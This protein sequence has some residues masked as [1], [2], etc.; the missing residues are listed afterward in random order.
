MRDTLRYVVL[1]GVFILPFLPL[2]VTGSLFFPYITGKNFAFRIIVEIIFAAWVLLALY[3]ARYRPQFSWILAAFGGFVSIMLVANVFGESPVRSFWS[4]F[5][6]MEGWITLVHLLAYFVVAAAVLTTEK[7]WDWFFNASLAAA[8]VVSLYAGFQLLGRV[9]IMQGGLR[10]DA[11]LGNAIYMAVYM[12]FHAFIALFMM[13]RTNIMQL[14]ILYGGLALVFMFLLVQTATR[15]TIL[16]LVGGLAVTGLYIALFSKGNVLL[17]KAALLGLVLVVAISAAFYMARDTAFVRESPILSR[18]ASISLEAGATRFTIWSIAL[19]GVAER[20]I[21]G[22]GQGNFDYVFNKYYRPSLYAQEPWFDRVHNIILDWMV[23]GGVLGLAAYL[24]IWLAALYY[25][26]VRPLLKKDETFSVLERGILLGLLA[27]YAIHNIFVFDNLISYFFFGTMLVFIHT[28]VG[29]PI[30]ALSRIRIDGMM[31]NRIAAPVAA[32]ILCVGVYYLNIPHIAAAKD[33]IQGLSFIN[34]AKDNPTISPQQREVF[35]RSGLAEF[36]QALDRNSFANQEIREHLAL[37]MQRILS[38]AQV[39]VET[40]QSFADLAEM[41]LAKQIVEEPNVARTYTFFG[42][43]Y[44]TLGQHEKAL[45]QLEQAQTLSPKKQRI[46]FDIGS[47][48]LAQEDYEKAR[49]IF[50]EA[51]DLDPAYRD[52]RAYYMAAAIYT[53]DEKLL[54][55][56]SAAPYDEIYWN[57]DAIVQVYYELSEYAKVAELL[58]KRIQKNPNDPQLRVSKAASEY[59][60]GDAAAAIR[61]LREAIED[62]PSFK[63]QGE[64]FIEAIQTG[65]I[66]IEA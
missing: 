28:R 43:F 34:T 15:G 21:L 7:L 8:S 13:T 39:S 37:S 46:M 63:A 65:N 64:Q 38:D 41:E 9:D 20:P 52:A 6:R 12:L 66:E 18:V 11:T 30:P 23:A 55:E 3:D 25:L 35:L 54:Q 53:G 14:R 56:L 4:N 27:G 58:G 31:I 50:K 49:A 48:Y 17:R 1:G 36:K 45:E 33:M 44:R 16:G 10:I 24:S 60:A 42:T 59:Q 40:K 29:S 19:E 57:H 32:V 62:I 5:E 22:W 47:V 26:F 61:T 2:L 51:F